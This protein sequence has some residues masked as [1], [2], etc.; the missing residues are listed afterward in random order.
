MENILIALVDGLNGFSEAIKGIYP[1][2]EIQRCI[3]H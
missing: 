3:V 2:T 1:N